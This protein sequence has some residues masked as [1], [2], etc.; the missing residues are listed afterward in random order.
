MHVSLVNAASS[1]HDVARYR[2]G[3]A[4][5]LAG[6]P[7]E[8]LRV[9][10]RRYRLSDT[11]RSAH[12]QRLYSDAQVSRL[13]LIKQLVDQGHPV[14]ALAQLPATQLR[15]LQVLP[16]A[17]EAGQPVR[18]ALV[19][20]MLA[21]RLAGGGRD[22]LALDI[23]DRFEQLADALAVLPTASID[24]LLVE[25]AELDEQVLP[26]IGELRGRLGAAVVV[27]Y[28]FCASATIRQLRA[29]GCMVAR[30]PGDLAEI[31]LLCQAALP[32]RPAAPLLPARAPAS[33]PRKFNDQ[34]LSALGAAHS[35]LY[36]ECPRHLSEIL[37]MLNSFE[38][39]SE[40][41]AARTPDDA[42]LHREL[43]D[44]A[45]AARVLLEAALERLARAEGLPLPAGL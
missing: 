8:T 33:A 14:G 27:L 26:V 5:R 3:V 37:L 30:T 11:G 36:C 35:N 28:R 15:T 18:V 20:H 19:G 31:V 44:A 34:A 1:E 12:G 39:Y 4:A 16:A 17:R 32:A 41:C 9:W 29:Q 38:R 40:Q 43:S 24:V 45:A 22:V 6:L 25:I 23:V 13:R 21:Q 10:E 2:S 7:V 42:L